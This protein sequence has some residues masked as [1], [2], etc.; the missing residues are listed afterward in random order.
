MSPAGRIMVPNK[1]EP[2]PTMIAS[3]MSLMPEVTTLPRH[4]LGQECGLAES[5]KGTR[6]KPASVVSLNSMM[7][8]NSWTAR[9]KN[10]SST[11]SQA[12]S[13]TAIVTNCRRSW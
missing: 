3:T 8:T 2:T 13:S 4:A 7:V 5:A 9:I 6:T 10:A 11:I 1:D 12:I